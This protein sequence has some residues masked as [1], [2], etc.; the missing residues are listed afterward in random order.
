[1]DI[2]FDKTR[3]VPKMNRMMKLGISTAAAASMATGAFALA[4][5]G[6]ASASPR[7]VGATPASCAASA[8]NYAFPRA[9]T[10]YRAG[11]AG[12][13]A[14]APVNRGTIKVA[15]VHPAKGWHYFVDTASGSSVDVYLH[16]G[17]H[18]VKFEAEINDAG[19]LTVRVTGC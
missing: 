15:A 13:V 12:T 11:G 5:P 4:G 14:V 7:Q 3:R 17:G 18:N 19:G 10:T 2:R 16:R 9:T 8:R 6:L 1:V